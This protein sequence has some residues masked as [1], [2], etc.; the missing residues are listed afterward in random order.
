MQ[1]DRGEIETAFVRVKEKSQQLLELIT[2]YPKGE[3]GYQIIQQKLKIIRTNWKMA[4]LRRR[5]IQPINTGKLD[6]D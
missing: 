1:V 6:Q 4:K 3:F 5:F 2:N